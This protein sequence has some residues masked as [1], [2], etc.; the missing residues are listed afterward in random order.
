[1]NI[2]TLHIFQ[3]LAQSLHFGRTSRACNISP[4]ALTRT[5]QRLETELGEQLFLR[6]NRSV[7][8][9]RAGEYFR[10][11]AKDV[12][13]RREQL[14]LQLASN[15]ELKGSVSLYCS[16]TAAYSV[17]PDIF[18]RFRKVYPQVHLKLQTG[19]AADALTRLQ[20]RETDIAIAALPDNLLDR[21]DF[22]EIMETPLVFI[23]PTDYPDTVC[24][25]THNA[26]TIDWGRTPFIMPDTGLSRRRVDQWF[27]ENKI[28]PDIY[29]EVAG[30]EAIIAMVGLG[31]GVG[32]V[33]L[34]VLEKS[35]AR[36]QVKHLEPAPRLAPFSIAMCTMKK[37]N[38]SPQVQ[39]FWEIATSTEKDGKKG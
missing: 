13:K 31:C 14:Q 22:L 29:A 30:N 37:K 16:V 25:N 5:V 7:S 2:E 26:Q 18:Q 39:A 15:Q 24:R 36:E 1:M 34:L 3:H 17:L 38:R 10:E 11:Y 33:P 27:T 8:L 21:I 4:S 9:T 19:D 35:P 32:V 20:N 12:L 23:E 6:D 28:T